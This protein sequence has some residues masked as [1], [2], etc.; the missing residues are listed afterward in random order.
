MTIDITV[1]IY[2]VTRD[3]LAGNGI[4]N[5]SRALIAII[6]NVIN[7]FSLPFWGVAMH[8]EHHGD[9]FFCSVESSV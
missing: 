6:N 9:W 3:I 8:G 1:H 5:E 4:G 2:G 7:N